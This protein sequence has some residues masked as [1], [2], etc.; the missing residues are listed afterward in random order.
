MRICYYCKNEIK[1]RYITLY[2]G[3]VCKRCIKEAL[4]LKEMK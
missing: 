1:D 4:K 3:F 2:G